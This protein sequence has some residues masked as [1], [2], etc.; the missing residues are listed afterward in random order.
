METSLET[1]LEPVTKLVTWFEEAEDASNTARRLA[2]RDRDYY[3]NKQWTSEEEAA[4]QRRG[5]PII[6]INRIKRK[7]DYN[8]GTEKQQRTKPRAFPRT[9]KHQQDAEGATDALRYA[10][11]NCGY[12]VTRS[13]CWKNLLIEGVCAVEVKV[14]PCKDGYDP[15]IK[16][17]AWDR[18]FYDPHSSE[19]DFSDAK[20]LGTVQWLDYDE[21]VAL[22]PK[23]KD[24]IDST[25]ANLN[26]TET[27]DD[28]PRWSVWADKSRKRVKICQVYY[29]KQGVWF[30]AEYTK[31][32]ILKQGASPYLDDEGK[33]SCALIFESA[34]VD[35]D[36]NRYGIVRELISPQDEINKRRSKALHILSSTR[37]LAERGAVDNVETARKE[38][39][40]PDGYIEYNAGMKFEL[41]RGS[42]EMQGQFELL[43]EA[44]NEIDMMGANASM[45]GDAGNSASGRAIALSQ[46]GGQV[47]LGGILDV[48][49]RLDKRVYEAV[50]NRIRQFWKAPKWVRV[51]DDEKNL[52]WVGYNMPVYDDF[53]QL[54]K[55]ENPIAEMNVDIIIDDAPDTMTLQDEQFQTLAE[56]ARSGIPIPPDVLIEAAPNLR[57][58]DKI[59][60]AMNGKSEDPQEM[61]AMQ[62]EQAMQKDMEMRLAAATLMKA[63]AE[64]QAAQDKNQLEKYKIDVTAQLER[65]KMM[66]DESKLKGDAVS[67]LMAGIMEA[68]NGRV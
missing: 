34:Y 51:T 43:Q 59:L 27:Y 3:D 41:D 18:L 66:I 67:E 17:I 5:Q 55:V 4:L 36:N 19:P 23:G 40:R 49:R 6:T 53:G 1:S 9:P 13:N 62:Q 12:E 7:I 2:E 20:Y 10:T 44:K 35:R 56:L 45:L 63:E 28:K 24:F 58:R 57:N 11:E 47:E 50:W 65:E 60:D 26:Q 30:F 25:Y 46:K 54:V 37:I 29:K 8:E 48:L 68:V 39:A 61:Q 32:G 42:A 15:E 64:A 33:P 31:S 21:A 38:V 22:Y 52:K 16:R 14:K